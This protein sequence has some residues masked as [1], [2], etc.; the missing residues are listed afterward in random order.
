MFNFN[1]KD[2]EKGL[3]ALTTLLIMSTV[4]VI[5]GISVVYLSIDSAGVSRNYV[6]LNHAKSN[7]QSCLDEALL[8][9]TLN[10]NY[11]G[12][13]SV[14]VGGITCTYNVTNHATNLNYKEISVSSSFEINHFSKVFIVDKSKTPIEVID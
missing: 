2:S 7:I 8:R 4:L 9:I 3:I 13:G 1:K 11:T 14:V 5:S 12:S 6:N 10:R